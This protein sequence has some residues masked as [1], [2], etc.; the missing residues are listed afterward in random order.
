MGGDMEDNFCA[1]IVAL[2]FVALFVC[3]VMYVF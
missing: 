2:M 1:L 3:A